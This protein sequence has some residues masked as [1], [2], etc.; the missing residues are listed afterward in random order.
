MAYV[1]FV[2]LFLR[3]LQKLMF[4][5]SKDVGFFQRYIP[6]A[7]NEHFCYIIPH[8]KTLNLRNELKKVYRLCVEN[9]KKI[10]SLVSDLCLGMK[11]VS[12]EASHSGM[13]VCTITVLSF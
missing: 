11:R 12:F 13:N 5:K 7:Q 1:M 4:G 8:A 10:D 6:I 2:S 3:S 9:I